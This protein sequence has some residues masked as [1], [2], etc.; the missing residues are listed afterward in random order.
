MDDVWD[1]E[2]GQVLVVAVSKELETVEED[3]PG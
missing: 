1:V 2:F 3:R